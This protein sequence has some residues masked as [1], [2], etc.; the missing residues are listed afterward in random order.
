MNRSSFRLPEVLAA[1]LLLTASAAAAQEIRTEVVSV[2]KG[3]EGDGFYIESRVMTRWSDWWVVRAYGGADVSLYDVESGE[4]MRYLGGKGRGPMEWA[5][6]IDAEVVGDSLYVLDPMAARMTVIGPDLELVR[7][8][9]FT[10][11][12]SYDFDLVGSRIAVTAVMFDRGR[13]GRALFFTD[14]VSEAP[15]TNGVDEFD[16]VPI[17]GDL[18]GRRALAVLDGNVTTVDTDRTLRTFDT[19]GRLLAE[20]S[21]PK[22]EGWTVSFLDRRFL[23]SQMSGQLQ[24]SWGTS[25]AQAGDLLLVGTNV[26]VPD[27]R[28]HLLRHP[29]VDGVY[30]ERHN[31][32]RG[33]LELVNPMT[34][35]IYGRTT[36]DG[37]LLAVLK[38]GYVVSSHKDD[39]GLQTI[40]IRRLSGK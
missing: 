17:E 10:T 40:T 14:P 27:W 37:Y 35:A 3:E 30:L 31:G 20:V 26:P 18:R 28:D 1:G 5:S 39:L 33:V 21:L 12:P 22:P 16:V 7:T 9:V 23:E 29:E 32:Y 11:V 24:P 34:G 8:F 2:L 6:P 15:V 19:T 25:I 38:G 4:F 36:I 13:A